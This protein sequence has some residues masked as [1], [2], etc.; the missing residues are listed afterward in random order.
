MPRYPNIQV[1]IRKYLP[2]APIVTVRLHLCWNRVSKEEQRE[3]VQTA[4]K[5]DDS[6]TVIR[7]WVTVVG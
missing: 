6:M 1:N 7:E 5:A 2:Q 3:F 4:L